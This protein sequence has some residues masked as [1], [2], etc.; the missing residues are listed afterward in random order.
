MKQ[1]IMLHSTPP[2]SGESH[3]HSSCVELQFSGSRYHKSQEKGCLHY[4]LEEGFSQPP[5]WAVDM[6][7]FDDIYLAG[8]GFGT[9]SLVTLASAFSEGFLILGYGNHLSSANVHCLVGMSD[10]R[11]LVINGTTSTWKMRLPVAHCLLSTYY[12]ESCSLYILRFWPGSISMD[13]YEVTA[14]ASSLVAV[15]RSIFKHIQLH[16]ANSH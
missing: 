10:I 7:I 8:A 6:N 14:Q 16:L 13:R 15:P 9:C 11:L 12:M 4:W 5:N 2:A 3:S 1:D